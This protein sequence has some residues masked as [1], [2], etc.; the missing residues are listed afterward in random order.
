MRLAEAYRSK[1]LQLGQTRPVGCRYEPGRISR[2]GR[3]ERASGTLVLE[4]EAKVPGVGRV[5]GQHN[6]R[7]RQAGAAQ[8]RQPR[9]QRQP[10]TVPD[11]RRCPVDDR[12]R[13]ALEPSKQ[14]GPSLGLH[15]SMVGRIPPVGLKPADIA[16]KHAG[17]GR[18]TRAVEREAG[19]HAGVIQ[20]PNEACRNRQRIGDEASREAALQESG[21]YPRAAIVV[22]MAQ[23]QMHGRGSRC[24]AMR[25]SPDDAIGN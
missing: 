15:V 25:I 17:N 18:G 19:F 4:L 11:R 8:Q 2:E 22:G 14:R 7:R 16:H 5:V 3:A 1:L 13:Q 12:A 24:N 10:M 21:E 6:F 20:A 23:D 9:E